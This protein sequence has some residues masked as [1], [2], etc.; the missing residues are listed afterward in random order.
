MP[1]LTEIRQLIWNG[2]LPVIFRLH[3]KEARNWFGLPPSAPA[4][5]IRDLQIILPRI[6]Y[7]PFHAGKIWQFFVSQHPDFIL[8]QGPAAR[9]KILDLL[10]TQAEQL[11]F[12]LKG[13][14]LKWYL[15][16]ISVHF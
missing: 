4:P 13:I 15:L 14:P 16:P 10:A 8:A 2:S 3:P 11:W 12:S 7:L 5:P 6:S 1:S 9:S